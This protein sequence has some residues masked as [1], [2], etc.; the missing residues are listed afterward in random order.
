MKIYKDLRN[1][2]LI[3]YLINNGIIKFLY[4]TVIFNFLLNY[5]KYN[6]LIY[7]ILRIFIIKLK[8]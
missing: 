1:Y 4:K 2:I 6:K 3:K 7:S 5:E 8:I